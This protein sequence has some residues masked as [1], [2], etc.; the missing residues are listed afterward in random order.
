MDTRC[1]GRLW[2]GDLTVHR[3]LY[4]QRS[5]KSNASKSCF[6]PGSLDCKGVIYKLKHNK[7][8]KEKGRVEEK[9]KEK[10]KTCVHWSKCLNFVF[11]ARL[12]WE[13]KFVFSSAGAKD[14][15][16]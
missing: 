2:G 8:E 5:H 10:R 9:T 12:I 1:T 14:T 13:N 6:D 16:L 15:R 11:R 3:H 7:E 4:I